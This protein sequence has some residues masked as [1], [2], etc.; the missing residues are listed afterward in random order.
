MLFLWLNAPALFPPNIFASLGLF[1]S[2][3]L[4]QALLAYNFDLLLSSLFLHARLAHLG[5]MFEWDFWSPLL[6]HLFL[7][8]S[9]PLT[10]LGFPKDLLSHL[11]D[12][13]RYWIHL[14]R[15][16]FL[17]FFLSFFLSIYYWIFTLIPLLKQFS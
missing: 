12:S 6:S 1:A 15:A 4:L 8:A 3:R 10:L 2:L 13:D 7:F 9:L 16:T 14:W 17:S 11:L 5:S